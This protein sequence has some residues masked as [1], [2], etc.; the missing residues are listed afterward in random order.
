MRGRRWVVTEGKCTAI[1]FSLKRKRK[2]KRTHRDFIHKSR[3]RFPPPSDR[4]FIFQLCR[5]W[6]TDWNWN[7]LHRAGV[8]P[9]AAHR[10]FVIETCI[11]LQGR[12]SPRLAF[13]SFK[14]SMLTLNLDLYVT[15]IFM[16][17]YNKASRLRL[18]LHKA[19]YFHQRGPVLSCIADTLLHIS[20]IRLHLS[21]LVHCGF[22]KL[23]TSKHALINKRKKPNTGFFFF[24]VSPRESQPCCRDRFHLASNSYAPRTLHQDSAA[25][26][27]GDSVGEPRHGHTLSRQHRYSS[28]WGQGAGGGCCRGIVTS[29]SLQTWPFDHIFCFIHSLQDILW[30]L[31]N[32]KHSYCRA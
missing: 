19:C 15:L 29:V 5:S 2:K 7:S 31:S 30:A 21:M 22:L 28:K 16:L 32:Q 4:F 13:E 14:F 3:G 27:L 20:W 18:K 25:F 6:R 1:S 9:F 26:T 24:F 23:V 11:F 10:E 8:D 17:T 12:P